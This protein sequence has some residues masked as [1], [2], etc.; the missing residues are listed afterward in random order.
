MYITCESNLEY[1]CNG[2]GIDT[3]EDG[4]INLE[5]ESIYSRTNSK[6]IENS[7]EPASAGVDAEVHTYTLY[8]WF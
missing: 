2:Y 4:K 8:S 6:L 1:E 7:I 5:D 3:N